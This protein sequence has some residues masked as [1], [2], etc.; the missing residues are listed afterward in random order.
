MI[1]PS[2]AVVVLLLS[3]LTAVLPITSAQ[4]I[5]EDSTNT[6]D[7]STSAAPPR[8]LVPGILDPGPQ[9]NNTLRFG[10]LM[11]LNLTQP[12]DAYWRT[13]VIHTVT[14]RKNTKA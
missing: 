13:L 9:P 6:L 2:I 5:P 11:P 7:L 14:V 8:E 3:L 10:V 12:E 1:V 4:T